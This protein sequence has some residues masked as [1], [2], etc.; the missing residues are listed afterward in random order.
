MS[1]VGRLNEPLVEV[2]GIRFADERVVANW[3]SVSF[4]DPGRR[5]GQEL[6]GDR[7]RLWLPLQKRRIIPPVQ[8]GPASQFVQHLGIISGGGAK[9]GCIIIRQHWN[10]PWVRT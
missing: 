9:C 1:D 4:E 5:P 10:L 2:H 7:D 6:G 3:G 8:N